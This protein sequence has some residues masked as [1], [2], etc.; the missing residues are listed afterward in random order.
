MNAFFEMYRRYYKPYTLALLGVA[1]CLLFPVAEGSMMAGISR[2][3][4][5]DVLQ[6]NLT[7]SPVQH[8]QPMAFVESNE[9]MPQLPAETTSSAEAII[10][11]NGALPADGWIDQPALE[12]RDIDADGSLEDRMDQRT[13]L[14]TSQKLRLL[15]IIVVAM[16]VLHLFAVGMSTWSW[17]I[18]GWI[19]EHII[20]QMRRHVHDKLLRLQMSFHDQH[21]TGRLLSRAIDDIRAIEDNFVPIVTQFGTFLGL[22]VVNVSIMFYINVKMAS[23]AILAM[24]CFAFVYHLFWERIRDLSREQ[25]KQN[26][27]IYGLIRDRLANP[28]VVKG[29]GQEKRELVTFYRGATDLFRRNRDIIKQ[30]NALGMSCS[31]IGSTV[32]ALTLGYGIVLLQRGEITLGYLLFFHSVC[33]GL[34]WPIAVISHYVAGAQWLSVCSSRILDVLDEP[35]T[36]ANRAGARRLAP[37]AQG[38]RFENV[39]FSFEGCDTP[40]VKDFSLVVPKGTQ[41]CVMGKSGAGK[42]TVGSLLLRL[43]DV[44]EGRILIDGVDLRDATIGSLRERIAFVP[45]EPILFSGTLAKNIMYGNPRAT[46]QQMIAAAKAA[47]I[48]E[49][50]ESQPAG[51]DTVV[52]EN[53]LRLSGGQKQRLSLARALLNEPDILVLDDC[54]S[55]LDAKTEAKIQRTLKTAL[56]GKTVI[57]ISHRASAASNSDNVVVLDHGAIVETGSHEELLERRGAYWNL[58]RDQLEERQTVEMSATQHLATSAAA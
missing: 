33:H 14:P 58:V 55:A 1:A 32:T 21:M 19:T 29:Y 49:F 51:Y 12:I 10:N 36:I 34:F 23:L 24:P 39:G 46:R 20:F 28:R 6:I 37:V 57:M 9:A 56:A 25:R 47:E 50:I 38:I 5:D 42:S 2:Y 13:G 31:V 22:I 43:Y 53:G 54:T 30:N 15:A 11:G 45:Q 16:V 35:I 27:A 8:G 4:V 40:A 18:L 3:L 17:V 7:G 41:V 52:G 26:S 48:H 44:N